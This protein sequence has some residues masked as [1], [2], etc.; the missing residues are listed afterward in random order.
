YG[1]AGERPVVEIT[2]ITSR[3]E[4][5]F[6]TIYICKPPTENVYLTAIPKAASL[7]D[8]LKKVIP[9]VRDVYLT[10]GGCGKYHAVVSIHKTHEGEGK[11]ALLSVLSSHM[12]VKHAV[13]VDT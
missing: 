11:Q 6:Q 12:G 4:P 7:Y 1:P 8:V 13:V 2:A 3:A 5:I 9:G 10:P